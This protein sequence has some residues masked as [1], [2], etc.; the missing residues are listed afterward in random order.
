MKKW[1]S[2]FKLLTMEV[3]ILLN[4]LLIRRAIKRL[5]FCLS[6][7]IFWLFEAIY[8]Y[9]N[10]NREKALCTLAASALVGGSSLLSLGIL[11]GDQILKWLSK[12]L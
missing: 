8:H 12:V 11:Y 9:T 3:L 2:E 4:K 6:L 1:K 10:A 7:G 5:I